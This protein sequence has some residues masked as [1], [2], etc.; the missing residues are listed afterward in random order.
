MAAPT[1]RVGVVATAVAEACVVADDAEAV[2]EHGAVL[3][4]LAVDQA[5]DP[6]FWPCM[7]VLRAG[8]R[9]SAT[10]SRFLAK[11]GRR[12]AAAGSIIA[13]KG[14]PDGQDVRRLVMPALA[15]SDGA[16]AT[17]ILVSSTGA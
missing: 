17:A 7:P 16:A 1:A 8:E 6:S 10:T 15:G 12:R 14:C 2:G 13:A 5:A 11:S 9:F 4:V 3:E